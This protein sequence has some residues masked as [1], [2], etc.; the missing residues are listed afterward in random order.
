MYKSSK[1]I[2][3]M[4]TSKN[5]KKFIFI[6]IGIYIKSEINNAIKVNTSFDNHIV[7]VFLA[8]F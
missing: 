5:L 4:S 8:I 2:K 7:I 3:I 1:V 6:Y